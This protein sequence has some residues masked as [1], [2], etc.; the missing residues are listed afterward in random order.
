[1]AEKYRKNTHQGAFT[2]GVQTIIR[3]IA[4]APPWQE[5]RRTGRWPIPDIIPIKRLT[6][7][8]AEERDKAQR[9]IDGQYAARRKAVDQ[10]VQK[11]RQRLQ[12][13]TR[14]TRKTIP[15]DK[16]RYIIAGRVVE[17]T[18]RVGLANIKVSAFDLDRKYDDRLGSTRTDALGYFRIDYSA[19]DFKDLGDKTPE[20][21][22]EV[23][24]EDGQVVYTSKK[25]FIQKAGKSEY[26]EVKL[27]G[28]DVPRGLAQ[29]RKIDASIQLRLKAFDRRR[30][31]PVKGKAPQPKK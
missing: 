3:E 27:K 22:I 26:L 25:S 29:G 5:K 31:L 1:M 17:K 24:G 21:Y 30:L 14:R 2:A 6:D 4:A 20:T 7:G 19:E 18:S 9:Q 13:Y 16:D 12:A 15:K 10:V 23:I 11:R 8:V 28:D